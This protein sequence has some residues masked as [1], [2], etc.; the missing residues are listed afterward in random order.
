MPAAHR[1][2]V[3][4]GP[5]ASGKS[6]LAAR[7]AARLGGEVLSADAMAVYR[8]MDVGTAKPGAAECAL[9]PHHLVSV[10]DPADRCDVSR[11]LDLAE[12]VLA[13]LRAR[14]APAI[15]AGGSPLYTKALIE[16]L[17]A[18]P[19]RDETVRAA[20]NAAF[21]ADPAALWA[22]LLRVDAVYAAGRHPN[23]QRRI[24]RALEVFRLTGRPYSSFHTTDR[25]RRTDLTALQI[26]LQWDRA[27][28]HERIA[29]RCE[30]MFA[31]GLVD[32][33]RGLKDRLC[34]EARQAVGYKEA[35]DFLD[36][37]HDLA[38]ARTLVERNTRH[39]AKHQMTW[40]RRFPDIVWLD[41]AATDLLERVE[42]LARKF[43]RDGNPSP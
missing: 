22:E 1:I 15:V 39:L 21:I 41:G 3:V 36:G 38:T 10:L 29:K 26:G 40:Y 18:G 4:I 6:L 31:A 5:T 27:V 25:R 19:P 42:A 9:A 16:G 37:K 32:E 17:S 13:G 20:L 14:G 8:G 43:L 28:L 24:V 7:L 11:W 30:A 35:L 23:D 12:G 34:P 33:V 2:I